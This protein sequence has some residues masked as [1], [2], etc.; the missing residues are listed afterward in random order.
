M[1]TLQMHPMH[2]RLF[3]STAVRSNKCAS[4]AT[5]EEKEQSL[6]AMERAVF[7]VLLHNT[8]TKE[9]STS[10]GEKKTR[11][12]RATSRG[13]VK[14]FVDGNGIPQEGYE[15]LSE[16]DQHSLCPVGPDSWHKFKRGDRKH[17]IAKYL[18]P[19]FF[20]DSSPCFR[21]LEIKNFYE[22]NII[23]EI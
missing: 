3:F 20:Q 16:D 2:V 9:I 12:R 21:R 14:K 1:R 13:K 15:I 19:I 23:V 7:A 8:R 18:D 11:G 6:N 5:D 17:N 22:G 10:K 4:M